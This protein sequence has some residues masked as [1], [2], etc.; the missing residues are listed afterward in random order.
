M[1]QFGRALRAH[2]AIVENKRLSRVLRVVKAYQDIQKTPTVQTNSS[3]DGYEKRV[4]RI[5]GPSYEISA[6]PAEAAEMT[7]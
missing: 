7:S 3:K 1:T 2:T 5:Y 6:P 4:R